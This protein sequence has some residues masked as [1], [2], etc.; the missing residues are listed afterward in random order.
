MPNV[1]TIDLD[2]ELVDSHESDIYDALVALET[3]TADASPEIKAAVLAVH[4]K[5]A[6]ARDDLWA[7]IPEEDRPARRSGGGKTDP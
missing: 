3:A 4:Q 1:T 7:A 2:L 6:A 5:A